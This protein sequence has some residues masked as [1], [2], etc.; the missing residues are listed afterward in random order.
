MIARGALNVDDEPVHFGA[1]SPSVVVAKLGDEERTLLGFSA[2]V[3]GP[4]P[5][6]A[7]RI[8]PATATAAAEDVARRGMKSGEVQSVCAA[9]EVALDR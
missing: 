7:V 9:A 8:E 3:S 5:H 1:E 2:A 6:P 4:D